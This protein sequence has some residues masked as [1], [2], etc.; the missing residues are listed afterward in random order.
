MVYNVVIQLIEA[1]LNTI[2]HFYFLQD[3]IQNTY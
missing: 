3:L 2:N 1:V